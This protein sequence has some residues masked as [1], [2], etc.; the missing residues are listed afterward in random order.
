MITY[1][2]FNILI[3]DKCIIIYLIYL[4]THMVKNPSF[5]AISLPLCMSY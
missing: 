3:N 4:T 1:F 5:S 2:K